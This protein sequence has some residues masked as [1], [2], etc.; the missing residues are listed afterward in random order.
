MYAS[1]VHNCLYLLLLFHLL[2][3]EFLK[4]KY[5]ALLQSFPKEHL[6]TLDCLQDYLTDDCICVV[7]GC[8][9]ANMANKIILECMASKL[10][11]KEDLLDFFDQLEKI[12][13]T[14]PI[15]NELRQG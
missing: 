4:N 6:S 3:L 13:G 8:T 7:V 9:D 1:L 15:V 12:T 10:T 14:G 5:S 2:D 11:C